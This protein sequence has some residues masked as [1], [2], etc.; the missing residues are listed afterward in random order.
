MYLCPPPPPW[1]GDQVIPPGTGFP[2]R[3]LLQPSGLWWTYSTPLPHGTMYASRKQKFR[4][5]LLWSIYYNQSFRHAYHPTRY[6]INKCPIINKFVR[7]E[8]FVHNYFL[9]FS[10]VLIIDTASWREHGKGRL[11]LLLLLFSFTSLFL[12]HVG[13]S[14]QFRQ[15]AAKFRKTCVRKLYLLN[16]S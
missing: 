2:F 11:L 7:S 1:Q 6:N 3:R 16:L 12:E 5:F 14:V 9:C 10:T 15:R 13:L 8:A 4:D